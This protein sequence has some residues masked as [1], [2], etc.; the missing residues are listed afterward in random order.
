T[1]DSQLDYE[2]KADGELTLEIADRYG[3]GGPEYAYRLSVGPPRPDFQIQLLLTN[4][5]AARLGVPRGQRLSPGGPGATGAFN[6][7]AGSMTPVNFLV[8]PTGR[9]GRVTVTAEG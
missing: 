9:P 8:T 4:P 2:A 3:E 5:N 1:A 6:L 7:K